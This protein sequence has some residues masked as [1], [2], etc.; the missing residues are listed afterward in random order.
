MRN[1]YDDRR[2][3]SDK[4]RLDYV[5]SMELGAFGVGSLGDM[6]FLH[7]DDTIMHAASRTEIIHGFSPLHR[8]K[9]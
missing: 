3:I 4:G 9:N 7:W 8:L 6:I 5:I 2:D 1:G